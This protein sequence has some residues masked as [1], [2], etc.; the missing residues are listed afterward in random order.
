MCKL[1]EVLCPTCVLWRYIET[2]PDGKLLFPSFNYQD[3]LKSIKA[4]CEKIGVG[5]SS[6]IGTQ[7]LRRGALQSCE[8]LGIPE[9]RLH[10]AGMW[11][12]NAIQEY[13]DYKKQEEKKLMTLSINDE[14][15][16][17]DSDHECGL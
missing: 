17:D 11:N 4:A 10:I 3:A 2:I 13:R 12:S 16:S 8:R 5:Q 9:K 1:S 7:S 14:E 15:S 6:L